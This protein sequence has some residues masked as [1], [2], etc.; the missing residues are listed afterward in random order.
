MPWRETCAMSERLKFVALAEEGDE[1]MA[2]LCRGF[3]ISRKTG[4][5]VLARYAVEGLDGLRD[6][7]HTSHHHPHAVSEALERRV[8]ILRGEHPSWGPRKL[9]A[10]L[11]MVAP[12]VPWP[13]A[14]TIGEILRRRGLVVPRRRRPR[15][16]ADLLPFA[17]CTG[18]NDSWCI[19]FKGWFRTGDG[20]RCD[21][22]TISDAHSRFLLRC[23]AVR[24]TDTRG[25]RPLVEA[26]FREYGLP[27]AIRS[28]NGPPFASRS[29]G[30]LSQLSVWWIK[31]GI[32]PE[33]ITPGRPSQNGRHERMHGTLEREACQPPAS[34]R[35]TQQQRFDAF[36]R[37]YNEE[38]PHEALANATPGMI[39]RPSPRPYPARLPEL[40]YPDHWQVRQVRH[41]G[42]I[43]WQGALLFLSELL[44]GEPVGLE[45]T[46]AGWS[47]HFGPILLGTIDHASRF[48]KSGV[49]R[50]GALRSRM[51]SRAAPEM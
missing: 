9:R 14:S 33:R 47:L 12:E 2:A 6:R 51:A 37:I 10:R 49:R 35:R 30:G 22:L 8:V 29:L 43:K 18:P 27:R 5:E 32:R 46:A 34:N 25:L 38:R 19:D 13:A 17:D 50:R 15:T 4:Y 7:S 23:Q 39:Y 11:A 41:D 40:A 26:S 1:S 42:Y 45:E 48:R 16:P 36:R 28:D 24:R 44:I 20:R 31:L 21:P 3:G